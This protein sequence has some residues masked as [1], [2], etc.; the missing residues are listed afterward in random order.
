M[1]KLNHVPAEQ[2]DFASFQKNDDLPE[3]KVR[4]AARAQTKGR[5]S[6]IVTM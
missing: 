3:M 4:L 5:S 1:S 2:V 6:N